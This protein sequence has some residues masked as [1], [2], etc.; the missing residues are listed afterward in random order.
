MVDNPLY[1]SG[2][3]DK[4]GAAYVGGE[5]GKTSGGDGNAS[6]AVGARRLRAGKVSLGTSALRFS[7]AARQ[8]GYS[9]RS[10][11]SAGL[12]ERPTPANF[13][14]R[15]CTGGGPR[16]ITAL[17]AGLQRSGF[18]SCHRGF[19]AMK[20]TRRLLRSAGRLRPRF[21]ARSPAGTSHRSARSNTPCTSSASAAAG[22]AP[23]S[24]SVL[25][26]RARPVTMRSP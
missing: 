18:T 20:A 21:Y 9:V 6:N 17:P 8:L 26:F 12:R 2:L 24:S 3:G 15:R 25:S 23:A 11:S 16:S 5:S 4:G 10:G 1:W 19:A 14:C 22:I 7:A 13:G